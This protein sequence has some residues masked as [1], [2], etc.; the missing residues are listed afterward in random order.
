MRVG[1]DLRVGPLESVN[2]AHCGT[3]HRS[4][5]T[6]GELVRGKFMVVYWL[7]FCY[8]EK[9]MIKWKCYCLKYGVWNVTEPLRDG[10]NDLVR[11]GFSPLTAMV[12]SGRGRNSEKAAKAYLDCEGPLLDPF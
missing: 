11:A 6:I 9:K 4:S 10:V 1:A 7:C 5:P 2:D 12:L 8:N 3:T